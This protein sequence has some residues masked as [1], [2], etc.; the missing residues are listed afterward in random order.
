MQRSANESDES[1]S[2]ASKARKP[3]SAIACSAALR[4]RFY[5][6]VLEE[7]VEDIADAL[8]KSMDKERLK[9]VC[10]IALRQAGFAVILRNKSKRDRTMETARRS[11]L[12]AKVR[13]EKAAAKLKLR[14]HVAEARP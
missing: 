1:E 12:R 6:D 14:S 4:S 11:L 5:L 13:A 2:C 8:V 9:T 10:V 7:G 3:S